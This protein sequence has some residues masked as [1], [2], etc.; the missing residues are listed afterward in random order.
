MEKSEGIHNLMNNLAAITEESMA[1]IEEVN[2]MSSESIK[3]VG[4]GKEMADTLKDTIE[5][6]SGVLN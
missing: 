6:L 2:A 1:N 5:G 4:E 3:V